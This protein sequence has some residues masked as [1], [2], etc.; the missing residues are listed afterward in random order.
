MSVFEDVRIAT[1]DFVVFCHSWW[2]HGF[3]LSDDVRRHRLALE[4]RSS[5]TRAPRKSTKLLS[6]ALSVDMEAGG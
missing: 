1:L 2:S 4:S 3:A 6:M 5:L